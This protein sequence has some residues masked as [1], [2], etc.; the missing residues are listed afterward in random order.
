MDRIASRD[1]WERARRQVIARWRQILEGIEA[2]DEGRI[3]EPLNSMDEFCD[4]AMQARDEP[5]ATTG[6]AP[7]AVRCR[8]CRGFPEAGGCLGL[9]EKMNRAVHLR[10]WSEAREMARAYL[11]HLEIA[12]LSERPAG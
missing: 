12:D 10:R 8:F 7:A 6:S 1:R 11:D 9:V 5:H 3:A 4:A 2:E